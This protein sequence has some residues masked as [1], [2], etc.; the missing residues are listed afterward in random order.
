LVD[1]SLIAARLRA[2]RAQL[3]FCL[4]MTLVVLLAFAVSQLLTIPLHGLWVVLT[5][6]VVTQM[7]AGGSLRATG[8]YMIG[9]LSGVVYAGALGVLIPHTTAVEEGG[10]LALTIAPLA[11][12]AAIKPSFRVAP[13]TAVLVLL[14]SGQLGQ[15]PI[16][17]ALNRLLEVALGGMIAMAVSLLVLPQRAY[18][19]ALE[20]ATRIL[21]RMAVFLPE[22]L[23][24]FSRS[25]DPV[26]VG[27]TQDEIGRAV[28]A[29]QTTA[30]EARS[31]RLVKL[32]AEPDEGPLSRTL[33]RL[34][35][36]LVILGRAAAVPLPDIFAQRLRPRLA[37]LA[38]EASKFLRGSAT[39]LARRHNPPPLDAM[40]AALQAYVS[41]VVAMRREGLTRALSIEEAERVFT[42]AFALEQLYRNFSDLDRC[43]KEHADHFAGK[44]PA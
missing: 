3:R 9:T 36:D 27:R 15:G 22:L 37:A 20:G 35:H 8:E 43:V 26:E 11:L 24:G 1:W 2:R 6:V 14:I 17:S 32:A 23:E 44:R 13:F 41:E 39:A 12:M 40:D 34:R 38:A 29:F 42:L 19:L 30:G 25:L 28:I 18:S 4:R 7:S 31:E 10:L 33:L 16:E 5:A 21:V